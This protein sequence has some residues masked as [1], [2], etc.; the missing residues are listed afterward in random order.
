MAF[1][2]RY[3]P[4]DWLEDEDVTRRDAN[5]NVIGPPPVLPSAEPPRPILRDPSRPSPLP[6]GPTPPLI[7]RQPSRAEQMQEARDVWM[8]GT[9]GRGRSGL[10]GA[11]RGAVEGLRSGGGLGGAIGGA[12]GGALVGG[13]SPRTLRTR[14]FNEQVRPEIEERFRLEDADRQVR[15]AE[16]K[17]ISDR[18]MTQM[19]LANM[20][21]QI[22]LRASEAEQNRLPRPVAGPAP[23]WKLGTNRQTGKREWFNVA[24]PEAGKF[25]AI[26]EERTFSPHWVETDKGYVNLNDPKTDPKTVR[27]LQRPKSSKPKAEKKFVSITQVRKAAEENGISES[28]AAT[29]F[30]SKGYQIV[31]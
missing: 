12:L 5:G 30:R 27:K 3:R 6:G 28:D 22:D 10:K 1:M 18:A 20:Q 29:A 24:G 8:V 15:A 26:E 9:E 19:Q 2:P 13:I 25:E 4:Y 17:A 23:V 7:P 11:L 31:R 21:S 16:A 14:E